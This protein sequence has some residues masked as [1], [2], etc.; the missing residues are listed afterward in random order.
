MHIAAVVF[1]ILS[2]FSQDSFASN[3]DWMS[4]HK[5]QL[6][7][8]TINQVTLLGSH[9]SASCDIGVGSP[10]V[11]GYLTRTGHHK[12]GPASEK[13][14]KSAVCQSASIKDQLE[15]GVRHIDLRVAHQDG[16]YWLS[17]MYLST[18]AFGPGGVFTQIKEFISEHPDEVIIMTGEHLY[19]KRA[20]MTT[21]EAAAFYSKLE[22]YLGDLLIQRDDFSKL[23]YGKIWEGQGR[24]ILIISPD[25]Q[26]AD[27]P[28]LWDGNDV[29]S[30]WMDEKD[31]ETLISELS[32]LIDEWKNGKSADKLRRL[33]AMTT[34]GHKLKA[35]ATTN[36]E[37]REMMQ[38]DWKDAPISILQVDD[39]VNSGLMPL[40][41]E[42]VERSA[43]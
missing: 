21:D 12:K 40:L 18:P 27:D 35:A 2:A 26:I 8:M 4:E 15:Y 1:L 34:T 6:K 10:A 22:E 43:S 19:S 13:D 7:G 36:A 30:A 41:I 32:S 14:V 11:S 39:A 3:A 31:P 24:I 29:D 20:P 42:K 33:Q 16:Q 37:V 9:D 25:T 23:T 5:D 17:H 28:L 38:T